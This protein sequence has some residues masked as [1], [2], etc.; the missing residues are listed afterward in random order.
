M[1]LPTNAQW[2][3][4]KTVEAIGKEPAVKAARSTDGIQVGVAPSRSP[5][6][7]DASRISS[8]SSL[9]SKPS[10]PSPQAD[11][12][13]LACKKSASRLLSA[14]RGIDVGRL[15]P[16]MAGIDCLQAMGRCL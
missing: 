11:Q 2:A 5:D 3:G 6:V 13:A 10:R 4:Y 12:V 7:A 16:M 8:P 15:R 1:A 14:R 9:H